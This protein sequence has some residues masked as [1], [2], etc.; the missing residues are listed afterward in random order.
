MGGDGG[1]PVGDVAQQARVAAGE[2]ARVLGRPFGVGEVDVERASRVA[3]HGA[4][5][6]GRL[7]QHRGDARSGGVGE[8]GDERGAADGVEQPAALVDE[9]LDAGEVDADEHPVRRRCRPGVRCG[10]GVGGAHGAAS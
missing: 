9:P 5:L 3:Q 8:V 4:V 2:S 1:E 10:G 6:G 7:V